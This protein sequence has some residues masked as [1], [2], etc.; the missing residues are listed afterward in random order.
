[1]PYAQL[2]GLNIF[3]EQQ[4]HG[5]CVLLMLPGSLGSTRIEFSQQ[6]DGFDPDKFTL[7]SWDA[8]GFGNSRPPERDYINCYNRDA[9]LLVQLMEQYIGVD[10]FNLLGFSDGGRTAMTIASQ[11]PKMVKKLILVG[12]TSFNSPKEK[13]VFELCRN[14]DG[15]SNERRK[16]YETV[17]GDDLQRIWAKWVDVNNRQYEFIGPNLPEITC[18]TLLLYGENDNIAPID[19]H[20]GHLKRNVKNARVHIFTQTSHYCHQEKADEFNQIVHKFL[21]PPAR[22]HWIYPTSYV[23]ETETVIG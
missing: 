19:P 11:Y 18:D 5:D 20:A 4:G 7:V 12:A 13:R 10:T 6:F 2:N 23:A 21:L 8:P 1:M 3:F 17:Y 9:K 22:K 14:V 15:W 16:M